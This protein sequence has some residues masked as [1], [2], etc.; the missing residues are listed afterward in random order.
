MQPSP[1]GL[2]QCVLLWLFADALDNAWLQGSYF[3]SI[4]CRLMVRST[5]RRGDRYSRS[6][7]RSHTP[8]T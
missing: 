7:T 8:Q 1:G 3:W 4:P 5:L 2:S 6:F